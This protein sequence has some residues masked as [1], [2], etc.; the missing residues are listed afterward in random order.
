M[1]ARR[2]VKRRRGR[3]VKN[4]HVPLLSPGYPCYHKPAL[5]GPN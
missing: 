5:N 4:A 3:E 1:I 2:E